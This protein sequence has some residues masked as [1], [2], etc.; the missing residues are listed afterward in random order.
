MKRNTTPRKVLE[1]INNKKLSVI[2]GKVYLVEVVRDYPPDQFVEELEFLCESG[3]FAEMI[4]LKYEVA[5]G[6]VFLDIGRMCAMDIYILAQLD[7]ADGV[8]MQEIKDEL[9]AEPG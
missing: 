4:D 1:A 3:Y 2:G 6:R 8:E 9:Y 5:A 7:I